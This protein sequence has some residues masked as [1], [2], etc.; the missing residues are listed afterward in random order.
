MAPPTT[1]VNV[2]DAPAAITCV[3]CGASAAYVWTTPPAGMQERLCEECSR[4]RGAR[5][6]G[7]ADAAF[8]TLG[9]AVSVARGVGVSDDQLREVF[10]RILTGTAPHLGSYEAGA[11]DDVL[12]DDRR[13]ARPWQWS[14]SWARLAGG[15]A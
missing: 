10:E 14:G 15:A 13:E 2:D 5:D 3:A 12:G 11:G 4:Y 7:E 1:T 6:R 9:F 8:D